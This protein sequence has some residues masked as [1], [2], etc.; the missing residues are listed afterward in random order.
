MICIETALLQLIDFLQKDK[1]IHNNP[2][3][4]DAGSLLQ[5]TAWQK[6]KHHLLVLSCVFILYND[7]MT[8]IVS[9]LKSHNGIHA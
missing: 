9:S 4:D 3:S 1:R 5:H 2:W 8:R 6:M 7:G